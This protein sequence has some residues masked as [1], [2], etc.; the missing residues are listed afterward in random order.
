MTFSIQNPEADKLAHALADLRGVSLD[1]AVLDALQVRISQEKRRKEDNIAKRRKEVMKI[2]QRV[3]QLPILDAR[4][5]DEILGFDE[6]G[7]PT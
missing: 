4:T 7:L 1:D 2:V 5:P 3:Q 6:N